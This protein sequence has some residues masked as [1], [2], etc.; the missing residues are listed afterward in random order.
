[1]EVSAQ[2]LKKDLEEKTI[3][4]ARN[5]IPEYWVIDILHKKLWVFNQPQ[6][7]RDQN[8]SEL[9]TGRISP[10][11]FPNVDVEINKLLII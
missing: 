6:S 7:D 3:T 4:Y 10:I 8:D 9:A 5:R 11:A 2:T 1:M